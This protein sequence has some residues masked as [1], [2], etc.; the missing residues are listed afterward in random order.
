MTVFEPSEDQLIELA[1]TGDAS[2]VNT[3]LEQHR[4]RLMR[5]VTI[6][7]DPR[8]AKRVDAS[9]VVQDS[10][11]EAH[12]K[13][14]EYAKKRPLPFYPWLRQIAWQ[15][16]MHTHDRHIHTKQRSVMRE[17][18]ASFTLSN[19]SVAGLAEYLVDDG[20]SPSGGAMREESQRRV[21][22][23][24]DEW[25]ARDRE[26]LVMRYLEQMSVGEISATLQISENA[27]RMRQLRALQKLR[28]T[29]SFAD[30]ENET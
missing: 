14:Q 21:R 4:E 12:E 17:Q 28:T 24:L 8:V 1:A 20:T 6:R 13:L 7:M 19:D 27:V 11:R 30:R 9:D 15:R 3:L 10:L 2:A 23:A 5:M 16:L 22:A 26:V 25:S 29:S 18:I